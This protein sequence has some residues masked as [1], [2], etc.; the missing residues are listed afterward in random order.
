MK[1]I[2]SALFLLFIVANSNAQFVIFNGALN[3]VFGT[4]ELDEELAEAWNV[5][6]NTALTA[7]YATRAEVIQLV[8]GS[9]YQYCWGE[10]CSAWVAGNVA[11]P[12]VVTI[13]PD[14]ANGTFYTH[15]RPNGFSGHSII[16]YC[17]YNINSPTEEVC[18]DVNFCVNAECVITVTKVT[19]VGDIT[20][21]SPNPITKTSTLSYDFTTVPTNAK[22]QIHNMVGSLVKEVLLEKKSGLV[23]IEAADFESGI[24]FCSIQC[25]GKIFETKRL[26]IT[27]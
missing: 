25:D 3:A 12:D 5:I 13:G 14:A 7:T 22:I 17:W 19:Q 24:Y 8:A 20:E 10:H 16:R 15:F 21:I 6:N 2:I 26:V 18:Y 1:K 23:T 27:K 11:L 4:G 9:N